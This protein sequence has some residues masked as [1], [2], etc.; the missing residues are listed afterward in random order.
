MPIVP[1]SMSEDAITAGLR[2]DLIVE[3]FFPLQIEFDLHTITFTRAEI[4]ELS[5]LIYSKS[6]VDDYAEL[7]LLTALKRID[8]AM[9]QISTSDERAKQ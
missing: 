2:D 5:D 4:R 9:D 7:V 1:D 8:R 3:G 6:V